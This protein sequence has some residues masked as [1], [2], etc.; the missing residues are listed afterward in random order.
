MKPRRI[1]NW[2][3]SR[4]WMPEKIYRPQNEEQ[5]AEV[6]RQSIEKR[7]RVKVIGSGLSWSDI[8]DQP[9]TTIVCDNMAQVLEVDRDKREIRLQAGIRLKDIH[10]VLAAHGLA[11]DNFGSIIKQA[12]GGYIGTGSHGTGARTQTL[13][14]HVTHLRLIDGLGEV[15]DLDAE[16]D[17]DLFSAARV[18]LGCLGVISEI[19]F[20]CVEAFDLEERL[21]LVPFDKA[22]ADLGDYLKDNDY[23]KLWWLPYTDKIQVYTFNKTTK[24][25]TRLDLPGFMDYTGLSGVLFSGLIVLGRIFPG[26]IAAMHDVIQKIHFR[27]RRRV[28]RSDKIIKVSSSIPSHQETEYAIPIESAASAID[29]TRKLILKSN[30]KANFPLEVRFVAADDIYMSPASG[31]DSCYIGPY[32]ASRPWSLFI[33]AEFE[34]MIR[35]YAGRP[36][37]GKSFSLG[38]EELRPLYPGY[39]SFNRLRKQCDPHGLFRNSFVDR[40]FPDELSHGK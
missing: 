16:H 32:I 6:I 15:H 4:S 2:D 14:A 17:P 9:A 40:V 29:A 7:Q 38:G 5:I 1:E 27:P 22:L 21:E 25:R 26:T 39:D 34:A 31:R 18:S 23:C 20:S 8:I 19:T 13:S 3:R 33:F 35:D 12:A 28:D 10:E 30:S 11:L 37:W 24:P 36:H